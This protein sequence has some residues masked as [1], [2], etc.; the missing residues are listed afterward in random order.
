MDY[1]PSTRECKK[2]THKSTNFI[3]LL[4]SGA[5][6]DRPSGQVVPGAT[7]HW[8]AWHQWRVQHIVTA[9]MS[10]AKAMCTPAPT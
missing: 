7:S 5:L 2:L 3:L 1:I 9:S 4:P 10:G 6:R 8:R